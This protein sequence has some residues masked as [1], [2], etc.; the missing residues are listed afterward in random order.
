MKKAKTL[1]I[2]LERVIDAPPSEVFNGWLNPKIPGTPWHEHDELILN[3]KKDGLF[4]WLTNETPHYGRFTEI[5]KSSR[6]Q[7]TWMSRYTSGEESL[8]TLTFKKQGDG[9]LMTLVH[10]D[11]PNDEK[12]RN[13]E[14]GW[15]YFMDKIVT[16]YAK[17]SGKKKK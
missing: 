2:S 8:V 16:H 15:N 9:T 10:S 12:A 3:A 14:G 7:L 6:I 17:R 11:L 5:K 13:H 1:E 4:Y